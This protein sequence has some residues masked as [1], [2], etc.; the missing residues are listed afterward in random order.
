MKRPARDFPMDELVKATGMSY[1]TVHPAIKE[2][3][4]TRI[5]VAEKKG[6]SILY[7]CNESHFLFS[8]LRAL[9]LREAVGFRDIAEEF[10]ERTKK[11]GIKTIILFGSV[12]REE[13]LDAGDIDLLVIC[14]DSKAKENVDPLTEIFLDMYDVPILPIYLSEKEA[15]NRLARYDD[16]LLRVLDEGVVLYGDEKWLRK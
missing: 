3:L 14:T 12:A 9:F 5:L 6:R 16:F 8:M 7:R 2:L 15:K 11:N 1:G 13:I 10:I 4:D